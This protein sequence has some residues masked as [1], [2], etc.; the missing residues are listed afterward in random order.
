MQSWWQDWS[1]SGRTQRAHVVGHQCLFSIPGNR[2]G[3]CHK[4]DLGEFVN[5][6]CTAI[7]HE[8]LWGNALLQYQSTRFFY[9]AVETPDTV[10]IGEQ[11][12][13]RVAVFNYWHQNLEVSYWMSS[14][15]VG[16]HDQLSPFQC[17]VTVLD[18]EDYC[19]VIVRDGYVSSYSPRTARG[20]FQTMVYVSILFSCEWILLLINS[21]FDLIRLSQRHK[22]IWEGEVWA[23]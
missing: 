2:F 5:A 17:L 1:W 13:V 6:T 8:I 22:P 18:S 15:Q 14:Q 4:P 19:H 3:H 23:K 20:D 10:T 21:E 9:I 12:G 7:Q 16:R 11:I